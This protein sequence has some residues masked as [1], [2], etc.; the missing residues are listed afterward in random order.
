M[1]R[2]LALLEPSTLH[3]ARPGVSPPRSIIAPRVSVA[4]AVWSD[5]FFRPLVRRWAPEALLIPEDGSRHQAWSAPWARNS[6]R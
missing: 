2:D 3:C 5:R 4:A 1:H 6:R